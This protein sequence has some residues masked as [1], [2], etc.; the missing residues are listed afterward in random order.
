MRVA[1]AVTVA[2]GV[3]LTL[4]A[5][6]NLSLPQNFRMSQLAYGPGRSQASMVLQWE[7]AMRPGTTTPYNQYQ[8][9]AGCAY[10]ASGQDRLSGGANTKTIT[11]PG[12]SYTVSAIC[13]C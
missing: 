1:F 2:C 9:T 8:L 12:P 4:M 3:A 10:T 5:Q 6:V 11:G 7:Q 13:A